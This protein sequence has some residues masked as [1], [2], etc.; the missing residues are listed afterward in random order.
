MEID[1]F[2]VAAN[3]LEDACRYVENC[4][5]VTLQDGG[6]HEKFGT[7]NRLLK[8]NEKIYIEAI[9]IDPMGHNPHIPRWFNLDNFSGGPRIINWVCRCKNLDKTLSNL[10]I[11]FTQPLNMKRGTLNWRITIRSDGV[12]PYDG[13]FPSLIQWKGNEHPCDHL[14]SLDLNL[15]HVLITHP[16]AKKLNTALKPVLD[17]RVLIKEDRDASLSLSLG[18]PTGNRHLR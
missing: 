8:L 1:H 14:K 9:A 10:K 12:L 6:K 11:N 2:V 7:H 3:T 15:K 16:E 13:A 4:L 17:K 5:G 18:T